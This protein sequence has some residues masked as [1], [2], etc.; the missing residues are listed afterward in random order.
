MSI[1]EALAWAESQNS[2]GD[3]NG[4]R[5]GYQALSRLFRDHVRVDDYQTV[6]AGAYAVYGWMP[7]IMK[8]GVN[9]AAW[10]ASKGALVN[11]RDAKTW[12]EAESI[13][14]EFP[15][16]MTVVN[17]SLVGTSKF[18]H[19]LNPNILPIWDSNIG[20][21]FG[22]RRRDVVEKRQRYLAYCHAVAEAIKSGI[23][24]P[25]AYTCF[26]GPDVTDVRRL[27]LLL[28]LYGQSLTTK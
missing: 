23:A 1:V 6:V 10:S 3:P 4:Y 27:E 12:V 20:W 7:T 2:F 15:L 22:A 24:Y 9:P 5:D 26:V 11:L 18:L 16:A 8:R 25:E 14:S 19:F 13:L 21:V 17:G 28:F